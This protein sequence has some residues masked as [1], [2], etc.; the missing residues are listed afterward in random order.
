ML[1]P[2]TSETRL[3]TRPDNFSEEISKAHR[4]TD[5]DLSVRRTVTGQEATS[6]V[7]EAAAAMNAH[8]R[9]VLIPAWAPSKDA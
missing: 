4:I 2:I 9:H 6:S 8:L 7:T 3:K 5:D 1:V